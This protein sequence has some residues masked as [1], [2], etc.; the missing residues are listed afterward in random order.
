[1]AAMSEPTGATE[2]VIR[3]I[4]R[5]DLDAVLAI[6]E[7]N[8]PEV[9]SLDLERLEFL[10]AE[11][12]MALVVEADGEV[13]GFCLVLGPGSTY[14]SVNYR[15]FMDRYDDAMYLDRVAFDAAHQGKGFGTALYT[16]V[17][18]RV[19]AIE[20][21]NRWTLEVN[22]DPPNVPSLAFHASRGFVEVG[23]QDT[24]YGITVSLMER[25]TT[26]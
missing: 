13:A 8:V 22:A 6:N 14:A 19:R 17:H 3:D 5:A 25:P 21:M 4:G 7:A 20:G 12:A 2:F 15:W 11:S 16:E 24:P 23:Q 9:S 1:V 18:E 26:P 10:V